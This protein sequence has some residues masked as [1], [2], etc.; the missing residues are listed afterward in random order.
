MTSP[1]DV[2]PP[3]LQPININMSISM[4]DV[5]RDPELRTRQRV[6]S[7]VGTGTVQYTRCL[8]TKSKEAITDYKV[9]SKR[10]MA[11]TDQRRETTARDCVVKHMVHSYPRKER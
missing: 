10:L 5:I 8:V 4:S 1:P 2:L 7:N 6:N 9:T 11:P 3:F